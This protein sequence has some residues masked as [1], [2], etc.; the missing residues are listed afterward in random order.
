[1]WTQNTNHAE[2]QG[3]DN[4]SLRKSPSSLSVPTALNWHCEAVCNYDCTFCYAPFEDQRKRSRLTSEEGCKV[5]ENLAE[6]GIQKINFVGGEPM[7]HPHIRD[8]IRHSKKVGMTT[9]I[10]S[11]GTRMD[12]HFLT[13]MVDY[14]DCLDALLR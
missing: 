12:Y 4:Y 13:E 11:N 8:W 1:M 3:S 9:S 10:V 5:I 2:F 7:L 14:L 6:A